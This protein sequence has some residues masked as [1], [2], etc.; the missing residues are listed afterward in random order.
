[1]EGIYLFERAIAQPTAE[2]IYNLIVPLTPVLSRPKP[3]QETVRRWAA[4]CAFLASRHC[5]PYSSKSAKGR[6][7]TAYSNHSLARDLLCTFGEDHKHDWSWREMEASSGMRPF[8]L[9]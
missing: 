9:G 4:D 8:F 2:P 7:L 3:F 6:S 1:M 5:R